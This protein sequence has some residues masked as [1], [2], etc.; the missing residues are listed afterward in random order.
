MA[1]HNHQH[2]GWLVGL[3]MVRWWDG[4]MGWWWLYGPS[5]W[6]SSSSESW[7]WS[8]NWD[9]QG[10]RC[11]VIC[12]EGMDKAPKASHRGAIETSGQAH[13]ICAAMPKSHSFARNGNSE[14]MLP[15]VDVSVRQRGAPRKAR[16]FSF[17]ASRSFKVLAHALSGNSCVAGGFCF[18]YA[19]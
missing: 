10:H 1:R 8:H 4:G 2:L 11:R 18:V 16:T 9:I 14:W 7:S 12:D 3:E 6:M 13:S 15:G 5:R 17:S 19:A